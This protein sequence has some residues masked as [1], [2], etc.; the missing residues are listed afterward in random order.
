[1]GITL[2]QGAVLQWPAHLGGV[3][4]VR[5]PARTVGDRLRLAGRVHAL[6]PALTREGPVTARVAWRVQ[7]LLC[8]SPAMPHA[9]LPLPKVG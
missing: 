6:L 1:M 5:G 7:S 2:S 9:T 3:A 4:L 8:A